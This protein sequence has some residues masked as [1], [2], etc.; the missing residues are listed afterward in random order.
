MLLA[1][2]EILQALDSGRL[3]VAPVPDGGVKVDQVSID[4]RLGHQFTTFRDPPPYI[5]SVVMDE[6]IWGALDIWEHQ[7][8]DTFELPPNGFV[9]AHTLERIRLG[10]DLAGLVEGRSRYARLGIGIHVTAP[11]ID[12]GF[13]GTVTLEIANHGRIPVTLRAGQEELAQ[14]MLCETTSAVDDHQAYGADESDIFQYQSTPIP[15]RR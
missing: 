6:S 11:K 3:T 1:R 9:L 10:N 5:Q 7:E 2:R 13:D 8:A 12:P 15:G 4:L 14:L